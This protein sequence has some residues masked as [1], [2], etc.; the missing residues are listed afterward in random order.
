MDVIKMEFLKRI[1]GYLFALAVILILGSI[2]WYL[3]F[4]NDSQD[5]TGGM[6]VRLEEEIK[7]I[8]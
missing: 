1:W 4:Y 2:L 7:E 6:L 3:L 8:G 5:Y